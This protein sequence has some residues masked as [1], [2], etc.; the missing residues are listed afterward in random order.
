[1]RFFMV[2][3]GSVALT[4]LLACS[5]PEARKEPAAETAAQNETS[6]SPDVQKVAPQ[7]PDREALAAEDALSEAREAVRNAE[8]TKGKDQQHQAYRDIHTLGTAIS[9][10]VMDH[11]AGGSGQTTQKSTYDPNDCPLISRGNLGA[12]LAPYL[13]KIP[14]TDPWGNPYEVRWKVNDTS[15][16]RI[17]MIR[18]PGRDGVYD[19]EPYVSGS[20]DAK[21]LDQDLVFADGFMIRW[22]KGVNPW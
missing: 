10:W 1:M 19:T 6:E 16:N 11:P 17:F 2:L 12:L 18:S 3:L 21:D 13:Q 5:K 14:V 22:P 7:D 20:F 15:S 4:S 8:D 9:A